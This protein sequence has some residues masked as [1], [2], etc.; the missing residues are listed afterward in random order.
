MPLKRK[1]LFITPTL[2]ESA[3]SG[4][5]IVTL[6]RLEI[7]S[8]RFEVTVLALSASDT[9]IRTH[10]A[11]LSL[12]A[13]HNAG[14]LRPR[15]AL[16]YARSLL[17][18]L[19]LAIWRNVDPKFLACAA[20]L[21]DQT[22]DITYVDHW[23]MWPAAQR[24]RRPGRRIL[25]LHNAE[26]LLFSRAAERASFPLR[27]M[28][29][30]EAH[31]SADYLRGIC[32]EA[33][34]VHF[35]SRTDADEVMALGGVPTVTHSFLPWVPVDDDEF[36]QFGGNALFVGTMSWAPNAEGAHWYE[37]QVVPLLPASVHTDI[38]GGYIGGKPPATH[39][40]QVTWHGRV[41]DLKPL[42]KHAGVFVAPLL[43]GSGI[44]MKILNA[45]G[46]GLPVVTTG[47]G[48][49]G[50]PPGWEDA[51]TIAD[52]PKAFADAICRLCTDPVA[53][54]R[55]SAAAKPYLECHFS[56]KNFTLWTEQ[57]AR[58]LASPS[59]SRG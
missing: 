5:L 16:A 8:Q 7:L 52:T 29:N 23:L 25:Q 13:V 34:E 55:A 15:S 27:Q 22:F 12:T 28:L 43:S 41:P 31:R 26:H 37:N 45:L 6:E 54:G 58:S 19:P 49:E 47:I 51:V 44:K 38:A 11:A 3:D 1:L 14:A 35:I 56:P 30:H 36:G 40:H 46:R 17:E 20:S 2:P 24:I 33:D 4:G 48:A 57:T 53:F 32:T 59:N 21:S 10:T 39:H 50:F 18:R 42:Y 9:A